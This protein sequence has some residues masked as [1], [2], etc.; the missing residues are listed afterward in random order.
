MASFISRILSRLQGRKKQVKKTRGARVRSLRMEPMEQRRLLAGDLGA[1][2]GNVF[3]DLTD[4]GFGVGT[5]TA[6]VGASVH[7]YRD[8]GNATNDSV[9]GN[10]T[11]GGD[12]VFVGT[13]T[14][15]GSG[16]YRF[17]DL[18]P[19]TYFIEQAPVAGQ[20][21]RAAETIKTLTIS[22]ADSEGV[23]Q[24]IVDDYDTTLQTVTADTGTPTANSSVVTAG[25]EAIGGER[26]IQVNFTGSS[27]SIVADVNSGLLNLNTG[28]NATGNA[29]ISYDGVD[30]DAATLD[31]TNLSLDLTTGGAVALHFLAS[32]DLAGNQVT[33]DVFSG[34]GNRSTAVV[35]SLTT[36]GGL[37]DYFLRFATDFTDSGSPADFTAVTAIRIQV[38]MV[39]S[40]DVQFD[41]TELVAPFVSTQNFANL[42]PMSIGDK[43]FSDVNNNKTLDIG[44]AGVNGVT[45]QLYEDNGGTPGSF[46]GT[47]TLIT[48]T[49]TAGDGDY[50]FGDLF[51]G[52]Y[53]V[54]L[55]DTNFAT[56]S[57]ALFGFASSDGGVADTAT[58]PDDDTNGD[59][60]GV[61]L[62]GVGIVS[63]ALT[64]ISGGE[65]TNDG[66]A[67]TNSNLSLDFGVAPQIDLSVTK[68]A[69]VTTVAAGQQIEYTI[70]VANSATSA[71]ATNVLVVDN[72]PDLA[73][74]ALT[75]VSATSAGGGTVTQTGNAA[76]EIEVSYASLAAGASDTITVI[77]TVPTAAAAAAAI[78]NAVSVSGDGVETDATNNNDDVD[79]AVTRSAVL[80]I[81]KSDT[82]DPANV[83][84]NLTYTIVVTNNGPSTATNVVVNDTLATGLTFVSATEST[85]TGT[86]GATGSAVTATIPTLAVGA[87]ATITV[88]ATIDSTFAGSTIPNTATAEA[89]EAALVSATADTTINPQID[90][91]IT[92]SDSVD[93]V[94]RGGQLT[95]TLDIV[96][97]GP[98]GATNV[99]VIDTLPPDV[100]FV[101][102]AGDGTVTAPTGGSN[103]VTIDL[104]ALAASG[105]A[106]ITITV[107]VSQTAANTF[108]N[109]ATVSSTESANGFDT[110]TAN[111]TAT[112]TTATEATVDLAI[113][114]TDSVDPVAPGET[115]TYTIVA[116]NNG[117][118]DATLV[119]VT[120]NIPD[121]IQINSATS[122]VGT[123][124]IP[125]SAQDTTSANN[126]DLTLAIG[127]LA[128]GGTVTITV[129][130]T[131][132]PDARGTLTNVA[133]IGS[134]DTSLNE[135]NT[136]NN[137]ATETT[138]LTPSIDLRVTKSDS[139][140]P[141]IAGNSLTYTIIVTNDGPSTATNVS[142]SDTLPSGVTFT[143]VT[144]SQG[145]ASQASGVVTASIGTLDPAESATITLI[146]GVNGD[147]RGT[148]TNT[149]SVTATET[150]SDTTNNSATATTTI[151][152][153]VD[154]AITKSD[155]VDPTA[156]GGALTYTIT[157]TNNGPSTATNVQMTDTLPAELSFTSGTSTVGTVSNV[158]NAVTANIGTLASGASA[159]VTLN[160]TV[161]ATATGTLSNTANVTSTETDTNTANNAATEPTTLAQTGSIAGTVYLD[162]NTNGILDGAETGIAGVLITLSGTDMLGGTVNQSQTTDA[163]GNYLFDDLLPGT[164]QLTQTQPEGLG[165]GQTNVGT[166]ATGTA[167]TNQI[168]TIVLGSGANATAF[169]FGEINSPLSK[170]RLLASTQAGD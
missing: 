55:P 133:T 147:T 84:S 60:N 29:I 30:G 85:G 152:G 79:V 158:G 6:I 56:S 9:G 111:N 53:I 159:T 72:L 86:A 14:S 7:V 130:A 100:T 113:T 123:V 36:G 25:A 144:S 119:N 160:T 11:A 16:N 83:G 61:L 1:I 45:V 142:L 10:G 103:D 128:S 122:T 139:I 27:N 114:K 70:V 52:D 3:T 35:P 18:G 19:G 2:A 5:D 137:T 69:D 166:G 105:T 116:T 62:G 38:D 98:S 26:D 33:I 17:D 54:V 106:Q 148:L 169:N 127:N 157:V 39:G 74:D 76:G 48:S 66:D 15:D 101:S 71:T 37:E 156:A 8:G 96:N 163:S 58:D 68:T 146:V 21:Q 89:D 168:S 63:Q 132:L 82:P 151:N 64:L 131:V 78:N 91:A 112:E 153:S 136:A 143:S 24:Q 117:P 77:V 34:A 140:D 23:A 43:V 102:A 67:D 41:F 149:A 46:D 49:T 88:V 104:G 162:A 110:N 109:S 22:D 170:R 126:D 28:A 57:D 161:G 115:F 32:A 107:D 95:Y 65:P 80:S 154:L 118:S 51:P 87:S 20:L 121:G 145:T 129:N 155:S 59:D 42:N 165:D 31:H 81:T 97:N 125:A 150:E 73:P 93:P 138:T 120:D 90:L 167:G 94:N 44:E 134:T 124:T 92:K 13:Q 47:D 141:A 108:T 135:T 164:Y 99:Q 12:D 4:D 75:I 40:A 50:A